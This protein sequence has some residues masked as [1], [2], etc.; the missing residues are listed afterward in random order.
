ML[1]NIDERVIKALS[2]LNSCGYSAYISNST[3][4]ELVM[5]YSPYTYIIVT[6]AFYE[7]VRTLFKKVVSVSE[8]RD[9]LIVI[10]DKLAFEIRCADPEHKNINDIISEFDFT[11]NTICYNPETGIYDPCNGLDDINNKCIRFTNGSVKSLLQK[12]ERM[13]RSIR[14]CAQLDFE[15]DSDTAALIRKNAILLKRASSDKI[16]EE[17]NKLLMSEKPDYIYKLRELGLLKY[18]IPELDLCFDIPQK[19]K[20]HIYNV[21]EHII[22]TVKTVP[23]DT[24]LRWAA[25]LHDIGKPDCKSEDANGII[26]F[27]GHHRESVRLALGVLRRF[28]LDP[29]AT[30]NILTLIEHHDVRIEPTLIGVKK[31]MAKTGPDLFIK[32]LILQEADNKAKNMK[33]FPDK[34]RKLNDIKKIY[35]K[36]LS[37]RQPYRL[38]ELAI[39]NRDLGKLGFKPGHEAG[40]LLQ[41]LLNEVIVEPT[42]NKKDYLTLRAK[43]LRKN[44]LKH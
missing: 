11:V 33:Y 2:K 16:I 41:K 3:A 24:E 7:T 35:Q 26:H 6:N 37:E 25:L 38:S 34:L 39:T 23:L 18:I 10:E 19:N 44:Y 4:R 42:K 36:V 32:L 14:Y 43:E 22:H 5:G 21:G 13:L 27:Y 17:I 31:I 30:K 12:P 20:Y 9:Y 15:T 29:Q 8:K 40:D 1:D 28:K